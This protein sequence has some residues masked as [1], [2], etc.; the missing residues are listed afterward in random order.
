M[1]DPRLTKLAELLVHYSLR[2]ERDD[3][4]LLTGELPGLALMQELY[5][6]LVRAGAHVRTHFLAPRLEEIFFQE[7]SEQQL[8]Y[9]SPFALYEIERVNK[10]IRVLAPENTRA[11]SHVPA[12]KRAL[13]SQASE[14]IMA[15]FMQRSARGELD[16]Q[17]TL[18]PTA[19]LAQE[20]EM[21]LSEYE[22]FVFNAAYLDRSD[23]IAAWRELEEQHNCMIA[24]LEQKKELRF[25]TEA[26]SDL[27]VNIAGMRWKNSCGRRNFPDGEVFTGP[28]LAASDGGVNGIVRYTYP[29]ILHGC[30]VEGVELVFEKG[31]VVEAK[32]TK[33]EPFLRAMIEQDEGASRL[34]EIAL[35][36]NYRINKFTKNIL[37]DEK[38]GGSFHAALGSGYPETGNTNRSALHWDMICDLHEGGRV[39]ADGELISENGS[40]L[41]PGWPRKYN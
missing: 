29:A 27:R 15:T 24:F 11:L 16:W 1:T 5:R 28:N 40:F 6:S 19:A 8:K 7:A 14:P 35:G 36:T 23:P 20:A 3:S 39:E 9:T 32:A 2:V 37:L 30:A 41:L 26:G 33:N 13:A 25:I 17:V 10:R 21:G 31:R 34:G 22:E 12:A 38:I 4:V 18:A